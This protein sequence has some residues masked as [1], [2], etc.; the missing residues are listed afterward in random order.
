MRQLLFVQ[1]SISKHCY[2]SIIICDS[3][4]SLITINPPFENESCQRTYL[5]LIDFGR[6]TSWLTKQQNSSWISQLNADFNLKLDEECV[7]VFL[8]IFKLTSALSMCSFCFLHFLTKIVHHSILFDSKMFNVTSKDIVFMSSPL[9]F[10]ASIVQIFIS[11]VARATLLIVPDRIL[12]QTGNLCR[13]LFERNQT[14]ILQ[15]SILYRSLYCLISS[16]LGNS[17][18]SLN[19]LL[20]G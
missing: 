16:L 17:S 9:T 15:V 8:I 1:N 20:T 3:F 14:T 4:K 18:T 2:D 12:K 11:V 13:I 10:D 19:V 6:S 5:Y 7:F